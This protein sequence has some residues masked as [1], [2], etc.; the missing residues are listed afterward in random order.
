MSSS[1]NG[2]NLSS[3]DV[4]LFALSR[5]YADKLENSRTTI[6]HPNH[7][8]LSETIVVNS[9]A[10]SNFLPLNFFYIFFDRKD[11]QVIWKW[12]VP[13]VSEEIFRSQER[14]LLRNPIPK[15]YVVE[16]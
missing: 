12:T 15:R 7:F 10:Q 4:S 2:S 13:S 16:Q 11:I 5:L 9:P 6:N 14:P 1:I 8:C 3:E